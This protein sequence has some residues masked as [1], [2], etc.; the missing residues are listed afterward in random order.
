MFVIY[1]TTPY[2][3]QMPISGGT[4]QRVT[5]STNS[6]LLEA[7]DA[8]RR[9]SPELPN[10]SQAICTLIELGIEYSKAQQ[11]MEASFRGK[12]EPAT[13]TLHEVERKL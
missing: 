3:P 11:A 12:G 1:L 2:N 5:I 10:R 4:P 8:W 6:A 9:S 7:V 13:M